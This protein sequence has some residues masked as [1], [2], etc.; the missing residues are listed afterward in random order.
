M[1][2][3]LMDQ[4]FMAGLGNIYSDEVLFQAGLSWD[5]TSDSLTSKERSLSSIHVESLLSRRIASLLATCFI[6]TMILM[7]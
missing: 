6:K 2:P 3:L 4:E 7:L 1:K 5:R